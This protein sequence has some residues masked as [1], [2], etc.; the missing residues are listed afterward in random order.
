MNLLY[1]AYTALTSSV[2]ISCLPPFWLYTRLSGR[3][4]E[5]LRERLG[6]VPPNLARGLSGTPRI[7]VHAVSLGEVK[8]AAPIINSLR[9]QFPG[10][11]VILSTTTEHGRDL[12]KRT[13]GEDI[14]VVYGPVDHVYSVR[15]A[16]AR[17]RPDVLIFL[18][19]EIWPAWLAEAHRMGIK[20]AMIN[21]RISVRAIRGYLKFRPFF[22]Q[23]LKNMDSFSMITEQDADRIRAM[24]AELQKIEING[25]AKY[26][27]LGGQADSDTEAEMRRTMNLHPFQKVFVAGSTR[28]GEEAMILDVYEKILEP[29]PE[30]ILIITPRH[31]DRTPFIESLLR[32]RGFKYQLR[33]DIEGGSAKRTEPVVIMN[34]FGELFRVYSVGTIIFCGASLVPLGGQNPIEAAVWGKVVFYGPSMDDFLDAKS[35]LE[36]V[37]AGI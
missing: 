22:R 6:F 1:T 8:V 35:M 16:L 34:T 19:T 23:V 30:T 28:E 21:G 37:D 29:F 14:P 20:T 10:C 9:S 7:W 5:G 12:A 26:D 36:N 4:K 15:E 24:G 13:F 2:F 27:L 11:S 18:E 17:V 33:T 32:D 31:I 25:N 3:Y